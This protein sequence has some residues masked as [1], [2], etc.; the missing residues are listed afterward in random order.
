MTACQLSGREGFSD[1]PAV[2][3]GQ[4][5]DQAVAFYLDLQITGL[6]C[7][8]DQGWMYLSGQGVPRSITV[9][10]CFSP[11]TYCVVTSPSSRRLAGCFGWRGERSVCESEVVFVCVT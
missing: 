11:H 6:T 4:F 9:G 2:S 5:E 10:G 1:N 3:V 8:K 7:L